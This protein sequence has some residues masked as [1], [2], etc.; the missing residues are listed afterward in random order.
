MPVFWFVRAR[1]PVLCEAAS[2]PAAAK[3]VAQRMR[4]V[5][6]PPTMSDQ[7]TTGDWILKWTVSFTASIGNWS[8]KSAER[9]TR[10]EA[11]TFAV[12]ETWRFTGTAGWRRSVETSRE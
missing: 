2:S 7:S 12:P 11:V 8:E 5:S 9:E 10:A 6:C 3:L 1:S 4:A